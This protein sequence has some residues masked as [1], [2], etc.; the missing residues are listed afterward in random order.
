MNKIKKFIVILAVLLVLMPAEA[1]AAGDIDTSRNCSITL[2]CVYGEKKLEGMEFELYRIASVSKDGSYTP[3]EDFAA[4]APDLNF[5]DQQQWR[6]LAAFLPAYIGRNS[7]GFYDKSSS[8]TE[9]K[10]HFS[11]DGRRLL[12]GLY[13]I[14]GRVTQDE[15]KLYIPQPV[16]ISLPGRDAES[17]DWIYDPVINAKFQ[18]NDAEVSLVSRRVIKIWDDKGREASRPDSIKVELY[19]N[20]ELFDSVVLNEENGWSHEWKKL[21]A[22]YDYSVLEEPLRSYNADY[23]K[24]GECFVIT[25]CPKTGGAG[26]GTGGG[27]LP[28]TGTGMHLVPVFSLAGLIFILLGLI[29][30]RRKDEKD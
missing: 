25:N 20:K 5:T 26:G 30:N 6:D 10:V 4:C 23:S 29:L 13:F 28:Q 1:F 14:S 8:D 27:R 21:S 12:P 15:D 16:I 2:N 3:T 24:D 22:A 7:I 11:S 9:G 19:R 17:G 18:V